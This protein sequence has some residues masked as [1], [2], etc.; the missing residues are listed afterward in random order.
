MNTKFIE[1]FGR[2][3]ARDIFSYEQLKHAITVI[4]HYKELS[5]SFWKPDFDFKWSH[6]NFSLPENCNTWTMMAIWYYVIWKIQN[7]HPQYFKENIWKYISDINKTKFG[8]NMKV[9]V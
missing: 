4:P 1:L 7:S 9:I 2:K 8:K 3:V 5:I 6:I